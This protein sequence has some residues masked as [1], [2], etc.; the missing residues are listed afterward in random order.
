[1][2]YDEGWRGEKGIKEDRVGR[3]VREGKGDGETMQRDG[4]R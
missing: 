3:Q 4:S 1:M 2:E